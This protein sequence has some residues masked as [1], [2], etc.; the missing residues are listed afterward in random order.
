[1]QQT[2]DTP[3]PI[4]LYVSIG[5]GEVALEA[6]DVTTTEV[7]VEGDHADEVEVYQDGNAVTVRAPRIRTGFFGGEPSYD[8][9]VVLPQH[10]N[11]AVKTGSAD[12]SARG[13]FAECQ[14]KSGSGEVDVEHV[15]A[16]ALIETGSG[17]VSVTRADAELRVK[18]GS[19]DIRLGSTSASVSIS[20]GSGDVAITSSHGPTVVKTGSGDL[21]VATADGDLSMA[22]GSGDV[23]VARLNRG[24]F[25]S[26]GASGD[27]RVGIPAGVPVWTDIS[28]LSGQVRSGLVGAG[29]PA[30]GQDYIELRAT[31]V[32]G[33]ITLKQLEEGTPS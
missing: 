22:T 16:P 12:I 33:D 2:Y 31:T 32:S 17:D 30:D 21:A 14:L 23:T 5:K 9:R 24:R 19:G 29:Q 13:Q 10:S 7:R 18:S 27:V 28:A 8:V 4:D 6:A 25:T 26:K 15:V 1:M 3:H 20:T 11:V